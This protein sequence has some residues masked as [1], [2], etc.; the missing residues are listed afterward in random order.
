MD[1]DAD[2]GEINRDL[3]LLRA[4]YAAYARSAAVMRALVIYIIPLIAFAVAIKLFLFD[5]LYGTFFFVVSVLFFGAAFW[6]VRSLGLRWID[7]VSQSPRGIYNPYFFTPD[8][9]PDQRARSEAELIEW[10]IADHER[11]LREL[12]RGTDDAG[13]I[14]NNRR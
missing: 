11:R 9:A 10:Q 5:P 14:I 7:F 2:T 8:V 4:R 12:G 3:E 13:A 6:F 1:R